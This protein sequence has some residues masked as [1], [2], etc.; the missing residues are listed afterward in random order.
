MRKR[1]GKKPIYTTKDTRSQEEQERICQEILDACI[2]P[3]VET[4]EGMGRIMFPSK[5]RYTVEDLKR[6]KEEQ[7]KKENDEG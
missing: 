1:S 3:I 5:A 6:W 4:F 2:G 7:A